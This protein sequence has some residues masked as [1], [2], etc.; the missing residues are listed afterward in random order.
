MQTSLNLTSIATVNIRALCARCGY[1]AS[2]LARALKMNRTALGYR[3]RG[4]T[5]WR[6]E[7]LEQIAVVFGT[8]P[9]D[10]ITPAFGDKWNPNTKQYTTRDSNPEPTD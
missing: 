10:L 7:E 4:Q 1:S 8:T 3:W 6:L 2:D 5:D 9:W